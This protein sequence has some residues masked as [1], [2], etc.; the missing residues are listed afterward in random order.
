MGVSGCVAKLMFHS[1]HILVE[2]GLLA[3]ILRYSLPSRIQH[4]FQ[5]SL[6]ATSMLHPVHNAS[7]SGI[8]TIRSL[9]LLLNQSRFSTINI[10]FN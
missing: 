5:L 9:H 3:I 2:R 8:L 10:L 6:L 4:Y 1:V 7:E